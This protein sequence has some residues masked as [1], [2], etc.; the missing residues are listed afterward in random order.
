MLLVYPGRLRRFQKR[1]SLQITPLLQSFPKFR[2]RKGLPLISLCFESGPRYFVNGICLVEW[3]IC[4]MVG[5]VLRLQRPSSVPETASKCEHSQ[6]SGLESTDDPVLRAGLTSSKRVLGFKLQQGMFRD[7][8]SI[9]FMRR[10][11][12]IVIDSFPTVSI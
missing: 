11:V 12:R 9:A 6:R 10:R 4:C 5:G 1:W 2:E 3:G 7:I 8:F